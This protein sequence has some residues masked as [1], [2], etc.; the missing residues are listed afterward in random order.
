MFARKKGRWMGAVAAVVAATFVWAATA[1][2]AEPPAVVFRDGLLSFDVRDVAIEDL[3]LA[4]GEKTG[5]P[6]AVSPGLNERITL[7]LRDRTLEEVL[8]AV[9]GNRAVVY[10]YNGERKDFRIVAAGAVAGIAG[11]GAG[12][13][14]PGTGTTLSDQ[15]FRRCCQRR[16]VRNVKNRNGVTGQ[17][18]PVSREEP[19]YPRTAYTSP[20]NSDQFGLGEWRW[21]CSLPHPGQYGCFLY[22][23]ASSRLR[24]DGIPEP[25]AALA[26]SPG[27][28][29]GQRLRWPRMPNDP[30]Y[31]GKQWNLQKVSILGLGYQS[32]WRWCHTGWIFTSIWENIWINAGNAGQ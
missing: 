10:E 3:L 19:G 4:V 21:D 9:C 7:R 15:A 8:A 16:P 5:I 6:I 2:P 24:R 29:G 28:T 12:L 23:A 13:I 25:A 31:P 30:E 20:R 32:G 22:R 27:R 18:N 17:G 1:G 11:E 26:G 14:P